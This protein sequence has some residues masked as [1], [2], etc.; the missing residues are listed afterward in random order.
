MSSVNQ[1][2]INAL[3]RDIY[4]F[5]TRALLDYSLLFAIEEHEEADIDNEQI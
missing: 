2:L 3:V 5:K 1:R 4:F